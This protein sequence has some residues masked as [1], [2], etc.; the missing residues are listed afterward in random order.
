MDADDLATPLP[1]PPIR[2]EVTDAVKEELSLFSQRFNSYTLTEARM[3]YLQLQD[4]VRL[5]LVVDK[6]IKIATCNT[7]NFLI[8]FNFINGFHIKKQKLNN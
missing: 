2:L 4:Y 1:V 5:V 7:I 3:D 8:L 6:I